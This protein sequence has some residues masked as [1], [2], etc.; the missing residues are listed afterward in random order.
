M[1]LMYERCMKDIMILGPMRIVAQV[2]RAGLRASLSYAATKA[3]WGSRMI[4]DW[5]GLPI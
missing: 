5:N 2:G 4:V 3:N 1:A